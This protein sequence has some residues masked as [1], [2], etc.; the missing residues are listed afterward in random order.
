[1]AVGIIGAFLPIIKDAVGGV[2]NHFFPNPEDRAKAME[3]E[4]QIQIALMDQMSK[5]GQNLSNM[6]L[7]EAQAQSWL[8]RNWRP[9][10]MIAFLGVILHDVVL[11]DYLN[12]FVDDVAFKLAGIPSELWDIM[13]A[14]FG[15]YA[16]GRSGEKMVKE[17]K[18]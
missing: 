4:A 11:V 3:L 8:A 12:M 15:I 9:M 7:A 5:Q 2:V 6:I 16:A 13:L 17:W 1:M 10:T 14:M 18:K